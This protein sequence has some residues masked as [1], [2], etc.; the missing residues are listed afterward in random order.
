MPFLIRILSGSDLRRTRFHDE[1]GH[2]VGTRGLVH[3]P[4][5]LATAALKVLTGWR[6]VRPMISFAATREIARILTPLARVVE[7][8]SGLSTPWLAK[9]C[10]WLLSVEDDP[11]WHAKIATILA[12]DS[13]RHVRYELRTG[14]DYS[15]L[16]GLSDGSID[17][18]LVDG[19]DRAGCVAAVV[20]K[21]RQG[22]WLYL[23]NSDKDMTRPDGDLR[24]AEA[25]LRAAAAAR[26]GVIT[27][28]TDFSPGNFFAEE[29]LL[30]HFDHA[31]HPESR[32]DRD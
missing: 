29:G 19:T 15:A 27:P 8:G 24:R 30:V 3:A 9:R 31:T 5:A 22:G 13:M 28:Y 20:P 10:G 23:D 26:G 18:A 25:A 32:G 21:I 11:G 12:R 1:K 4:L 7:F 6:P 2:F 17:F 16:S 14:A